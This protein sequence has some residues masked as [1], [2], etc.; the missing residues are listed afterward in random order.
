MT[1]GTNT[2]Q[3]LNEYFQR[4]L[5]M[6]DYRRG[7][8]KGD[9]PSCGAHKFGIHLGFNRSN[10]FKCEYNALPLDIVM[11]N[12]H[13]KDRHQVYKLLNDLKGVTYKEPEV[14]PYELK[15]NI[16]LP[17]RFK[18]IKRGDSFIAKRARAYMVSRGF[19]IDRLSRAGWGYCSKGDYQ[20]YIIMPFFFNN[21]LIYFNARKFLGNGPKYNNPNIEEFGLGKSMII[22]NFD[23]LYFYNK[24]Y[25]FESVINAETIGPDAI[26]TGGKKLSNWQI[27]QIIKSPCEKLII[28]L[29]DDAIE[30]AYKLAL[31]LVPHKKVKIILFPEGKD[32]ND[33]GKKKTLKLVH[34]NR[35]KTYNEFLIEKN[36]IG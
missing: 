24:I 23:A 14:E 1:L 6:Y 11:T 36:N 21:R 26:A 28:G 19:D 5:G 17:E 9:C 25:L 22:Y 20:G 31:E 15:Q 32:V 7:W 8:L 27:K 10:C 2:K 4:R 30:D 3:K 12:E 13:F 18:N 35:Y 34:K 33:L 16:V 29:D